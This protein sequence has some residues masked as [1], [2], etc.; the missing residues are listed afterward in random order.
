MYNG[1]SIEILEELKD[2]NNWGIGTKLRI[3]L[4]NGEEKVIDVK[5]VDFKFNL[6]EGV[7]VK[8]VK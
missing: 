5:E 7:D 8:W 6:I 4:L 1:E 3:K 2:K